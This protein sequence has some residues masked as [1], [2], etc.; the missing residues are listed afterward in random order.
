MDA[1]QN[2]L[3]PVSELLRFRPQLRRFPDA[4]LIPLQPA[5][6]RADTGFLFQQREI[7]LDRFQLALQNG[8]L[9]QELRGFQ[10]QPRLLLLE[11]FP[12]G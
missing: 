8:A 6:Q 12:A 10:L 7:R 9:P 11:P 1:A 5:R 3:Q 4:A 2:M